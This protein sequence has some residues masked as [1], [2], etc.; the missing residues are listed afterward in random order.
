MD[1]PNT[2]R[3]VSVQST[4]IVSLKQ[5]SELVQSKNR[6]EL[7]AKSGL[8]FV[9][10]NACGLLSGVL[11]PDLHARFLVCQFTSHY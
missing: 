8:Y 2:P 6:K 7:I 9:S 3:F 1:T 10:S 4:K 11:D 5:I